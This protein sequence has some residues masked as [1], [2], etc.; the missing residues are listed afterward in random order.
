M[1]ELETWQAVK[2]R[3][4]AQRAALNEEISSYPGP[5][6]GCDAQFNHLLEERRG[7]NRDMK[8]LDELRDKSRA[9]GGDAAARKQ[10]ITSCDFLSPAA[11]DHKK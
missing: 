7:I 8:R 3:L 1:N 9:T 11:G 2:D 6:A 5:I 10:F 4:E